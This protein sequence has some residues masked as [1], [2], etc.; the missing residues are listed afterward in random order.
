MTPLLM[1]LVG[2]LAGFPID[3]LSAWLAR[4]YFYTDLEA[5]SHERSF[6]EAALVTAGD[7]PNHATLPRSL[8][9]ASAYRRAIIVA[10]T[11]AVFAGIGARWDGH[12]RELPIVAAYA[13]VL[14][15]CAATDIIA[16]R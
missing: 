14:I 4:D 10:V 2:F 8:T 6:D 13:S 12:A 9:T 5:P 11:A 16:Y 15:A 3:H 1:A 7:R